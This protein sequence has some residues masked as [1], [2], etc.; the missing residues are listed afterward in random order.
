MDFRLLKRHIFNVV[1]KEK[2]EHFRDGQAI[3]I[4]I[5]LIWREQYERMSGTDSDCFYD[6]SKIE[7]A[8]TELE[9]QWNNFP[10]KNIPL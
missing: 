8:I 9:N 4:Y 5:H 3:M 7:A 2:S 10:H 6:D 1:L